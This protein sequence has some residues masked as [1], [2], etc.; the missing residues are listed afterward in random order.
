[1]EEATYLASC[2]VSIESVNKMLNLS[3]MNDYEAKLRAIF[4]SSYILSISMVFLDVKSSRFYSQNEL[5]IRTVVK[6][7]HGSDCLCALLL[8]VGLWF[9]SLALIS[10][11]CL[12][13][14]KFFLLHLLSRAVTGVKTTDK[15][16]MCIETTKAYLHHMG[17]FLFIGPEDYVM[18]LITTIWR[19]L[20]LTGHLAIYLSEDSVI[21]K[22]FFFWQLSFCRNAA[23]MILLLLCHCS[24]SIR[25][26]FG[27]KSSYTDLST[28]YDDL[29]T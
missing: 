9:H 27:E 3:S 4:I 6:V 29:I 13:L 28:T 26:G 16:S 12:L 11:S 22:N 7:L 1:M 8:G 18:I 5:L 24:S 10:I 25:S 23:I 14:T 20:S 21:S 2:L 17:N 15:L 19:F